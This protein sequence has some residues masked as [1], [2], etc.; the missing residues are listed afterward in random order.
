VLL[1]LVAYLGGGLII[2]SPCV[3]PV[4]RCVLARSNQPCLR[5]GRTPLKQ[6]VMPRKQA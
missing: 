2:L 5:S 1:F 4:L 6:L 3:L